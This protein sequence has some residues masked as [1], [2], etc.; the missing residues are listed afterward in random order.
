[1]IQSSCHGSDLS[2]QGLLAYLT[3]QLY[4]SVPDLSVAAEEP[5]QLSRKD[6]LEEL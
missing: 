1:M 4:A 6:E 3:N 5:V 2:T